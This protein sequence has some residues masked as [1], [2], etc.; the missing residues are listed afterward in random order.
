MI[1]GIGVDLL[2]LK[3]VAAVYEKHGKRFVR[4]ILTSAEQHEADSRASKVNYIAKQFAAKEAVSKAIGF[5]I[6]K[7][8]FTDIE[9]LRDDSGKPHV[10]LSVKAKELFG[11]FDI[12]LSLSDTQSHVLAFCVIEG[13]IK[14]PADLLK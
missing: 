6:G 4:R 14:N 2:E 8:R 3:R 7:L 10:N 9:V 11:E 12:H 1:N 13:A 5:G